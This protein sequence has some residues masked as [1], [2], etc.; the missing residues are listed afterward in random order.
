M[1]RYLITSQNNMTFYQEKSIKRLRMIKQHV[2]Q[3][4]LEY[5]LSSRCSDDPLGLFW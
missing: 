3:T 5:I 2:G 1:A 4:V